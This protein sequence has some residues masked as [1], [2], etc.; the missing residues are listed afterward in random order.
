MTSYWARYA[1]LDET[2]AE[3]V[4]LVEQDGRWI[5]VTPNSPR[6][7]AD[8]RL[9]GLVLAGLANTHSHAFHRAL[10]GRT[11]GEGG[12]FWTWRDGMYA[13]AERLDPDSYHALATAV[14]AEMVLAG[15]TA[16]GEFHYLH[17]RA[18]GRP[19]QDPN[20]FGHALIAA[21]A[22][23]G[24][25]ITLLDT[26][27]LAGGLDADGY[28][29]PNEIQQRFSDGSAS[30]WASRVTQLAGSD[31]A[32]VGAAIHSVRAVPD[33][34][35]AA[36]LH[37]FPGRPLHVHLSEQP[38]E[39]EAALARYGLTPTE[40]LARRGFGGRQH[41]AVHATHLT[42][43]DIGYLGGT[44]TNVSFCPTTERDL[45]DGI[46][47]ARALREAGATLTLGSDQNAV[48]DL[49][50]EARA[51]ELNERLASRER[52]RFSPAELIQALTGDGH[53]SLGWDDAGRLAVGARADL[54]HLNLD[55]VRT[56]G[57]RPEQVIMA[58]SA[59]DVDT[60]LVDG[61]VLVRD[62]RHVRFP[63]LGRDLREQVS[64]LWR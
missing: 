15:V 19:Y 44:S 63:E 12:T 39:N 6:E 8:L 53:R 7:P 47:P 13:L 18:G 60:V 52:G 28:Q 24:L 64:R 31:H 50:E 14:Y 49:I 4:R 1:W 38:A 35:L 61:Q 59:A 43:A 30:A 36:V 10:R 34:Q 9:D 16:V 33:D 42:D 46:G 56:A 3:Q 48:V 32:R 58:A 17:H 41:T 27:Y 62:G 45:A 23:A 21:A 25:R 54:V 57:A 40:L 22:A 29:P 11:H 5:A 20:A 37:A 51:L 2:V 55:T 26:C